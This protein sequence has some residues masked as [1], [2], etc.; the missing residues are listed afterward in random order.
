[1]LG[2]RKPRERY[3]DHYKPHPG[4]TDV[5]HIMDTSAPVTAR[6]KVI[7]ALCDRWNIQ[8][9][10]T[11]NHP[12]GRRVIEAVNSYSDDLCESFAAILDGDIKEI[13]FLCVELAAEPCPAPIMEGFVD[14]IPK[15]APNSCTPLYML[16]RTLHQ[17]RIEKG[18]TRERSLTAM[19]KRV[20]VYQRS[21]RTRW[22]DVL[23]LLPGVTDSE[24][25]CITIIHNRPE[26]AGVIAARLAAGDVDQ[27]MLDLLV[28]NPA[29]ILTEGTL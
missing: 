24:A 10:V 12:V 6:E 1:M 28:L 3:K 15:Q 29:P 27:E 22:D 26:L 21:S 7:S 18:P 13:A 11:R 4:G 2:N 25:R 17:L 16:F 23:S 20:D 5:I 19:A 8:Y 9:P 14:L